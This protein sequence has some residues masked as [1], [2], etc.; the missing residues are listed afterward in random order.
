MILVNSCNPQHYCDL[1]TSPY[2]QAF[3][4]AESGQTLQVVIND[5]DAGE[6]ELLGRWANS[7]FIVILHS[8]LM[9]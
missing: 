9:I 4:H 7:L 1:H 2:L 6:D 5:E 8:V 3:I